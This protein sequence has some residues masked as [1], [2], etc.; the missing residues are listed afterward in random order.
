MGFSSGN[1]NYGG[2]GYNKEESFYE[3]VR[4]Q[5]PPPPQSNWDY[6]RYGYG[7]FY[8]GQS[9]HSSGDPGYF[10]GPEHYPDYEFE[11]DYD[12]YDTSEGFSD[13]YS[14]GSDDYWD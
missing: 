3:P 7:G 13:E 6:Y 2:T 11:D 14:S 8:G 5:A 10:T 4:Y 9:D 12:R 1:T